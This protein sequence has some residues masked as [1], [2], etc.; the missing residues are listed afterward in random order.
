MLVGMEAEGLGHHLSER[1]MNDQLAR[2]CGGP[3]KDAQ[4]NLLVVTR[5]RHTEQ[6]VGLVWD[7]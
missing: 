5:I 6:R 3:S 1:R 2:R 4:E 7:A